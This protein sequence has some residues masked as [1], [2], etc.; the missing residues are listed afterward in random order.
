MDFRRIDRNTVQCILSEEEMNAYGFKIEDFF[1][2]QEKSRNFLEHIV[3]R[4][5]EE[6]GYEA[7]SGM[8][9]MQ[10]MKMPNNDLAITFSDRE[11]EDGMQSMLQHIQQLANLI[12]DGV[13]EELVHH[14][15]GDT[16]SPAGGDKAPGLSE[17]D[18][19]LA[20][21]YRKHMEEVEKK[22]REKQRKL[23]CA[24]RAYRLESFADLERFASMVNI[25]KPVNSSVYKDT[26]TGE[27]YLLIK[28]GK[29]KLQEYQQLCESISEFSVWCSQQPYI[30]QY[31]REHFETIIARQGIGV[32]RRLQ[33]ENQEG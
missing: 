7:K 17:A 15:H 21:E 19:Q 16:D 10:I 30:E 13:P 9:S 2:D 11:R 14:R 23:L 4:A 29:L 28:K 25:D 12:S 8:V 31:C 18:K 32:L 6:V 22:R 26:D 27:Y 5:G 3:E 20:D 33:S 1:S 24:P